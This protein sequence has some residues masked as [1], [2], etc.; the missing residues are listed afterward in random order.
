MRVFAG[1]WRLIRETCPR[2]AGTAVQESRM[3]SALATLVVWTVIG[4]GALFAAVSLLTQ[5]RTRNAAA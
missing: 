2:T 5:R 4:P 3:L 1:H